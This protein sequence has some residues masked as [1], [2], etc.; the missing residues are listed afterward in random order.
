MSDLFLNCKSNILSGL[1]TNKE[2]ADGE[3]LCSCDCWCSAL[4]TVA[5]SN[6]ISPS[7]HVFF[8]LS[9]I[10]LRHSNKAPMCFMNWAFKAVPKYSC[11]SGILNFSAIL[12]GGP[13]WCTEQER[14]YAPLAG[15]KWRPFWRG[16]ALGACKCWCGC[17]RQPQ[18]HPSHGCLSQGALLSLFVISY[19]AFCNWSLIWLMNFIVG[20]CKSGAIP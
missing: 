4:C 14:K 15:S 13:Y 1:L 6:N 7:N 19:M 5:S 2:T 18:N 17:S 3:Q 8:Y 10:Q 20:S 12:Q 9:W 11:V 16:P